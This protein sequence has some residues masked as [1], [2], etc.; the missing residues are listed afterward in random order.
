M[1]NVRATPASH[2]TALTAD[3]SSETIA[4]NGDSMQIV[5]RKAIS[6][7]ST[8]LASSAASGTVYNGY[9]SNIISVSMDGFVTPKAVG[10][11]TVTAT[12]SGL[13]S[14]V[15]VTVSNSLP[16][17][18]YGFENGSQG[19]VKEDDNVASVAAEVSLA[20]LFLRQV[21]PRL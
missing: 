16:M 11:T 12:N 8:Q 2:A 4:L 9:N 21:I 3:K 5:L 19:W 10:T 18:L 6:D 17:V 14:K 7:G 13:T 1:D 20:E 15:T